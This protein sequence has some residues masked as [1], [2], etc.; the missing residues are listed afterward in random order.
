MTEEMHTFTIALNPDDPLE[1]SWSDFACKLAD[2]GAQEE[3]IAMMQLAFYVGAMQTFARI[4]R[5]TEDGEMFATTMTAL[6]AEL[7]DIMKQGN[8]PT[9]G[10]A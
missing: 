8:Y 2:D 7:A 6:S 9:M 4:I 10:S 1:K 5:S 3:Q